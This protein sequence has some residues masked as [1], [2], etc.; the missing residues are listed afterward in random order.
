MFHFESDKQKERNEIKPNQKA[1]NDTGKSQHHR[2]RTNPLDLIVVE[3]M[4]GL[5]LINLSNTHT[6]TIEIIQITKFLYL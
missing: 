6:I 3:N 5:T 2:E 1:N 4:P